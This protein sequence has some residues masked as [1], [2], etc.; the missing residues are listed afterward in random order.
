MFIV[1]CLVIIGIVSISPAHMASVCGGDQ[2]ELICTTTGNFLEWSFSL[3]PT[4]ET[5][6]M[7]YSRILTTLSADVSSLIL[8]NSSFTFSRISAQNSLP[9]ISG[10]LINPVS[11]EPNGIEVN[12]ADIETS[13]TAS[14]LVK[15]INEDLIF[16][17][18]QKLN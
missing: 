6:A 1:Y 14:T 15:I 13:E 4:G 12:C 16:G 3:I 2:L 11:A 18:L 5:T 7:T 17:T 10:L 8:A 9:L